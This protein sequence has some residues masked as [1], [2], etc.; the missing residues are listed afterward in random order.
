MIPQEL[1]RYYRQRAVQ[2]AIIRS[3]Q[4]VEQYKQQKEQQ[5]IL[6]EQKKEI[7]RQ[8]KAQQFKQTLTRL[9]PIKKTTQ[10]EQIEAKQ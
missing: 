7:E 5:E 9:I 4:Q 1:K 8:Q 2:D 3:Q 6:A 10:K